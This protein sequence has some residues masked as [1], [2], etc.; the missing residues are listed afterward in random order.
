MNQDNDIFTFVTNDDAKFEIEKNIVDMSLTLM[1][2]VSDQSNN[3]NYDDIKID[4]INGKTMSQVLTYLRLSIII[5]ESEDSSEKLINNMT[6]DSF[7]DFILAGKYLQLNS[8][9][10]SAGKRI[11]KMLDVS[12]QEVANNSL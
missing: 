11:R 10:Q 4:N 12:P 1:K 6:G 2:L 7:Y 8:L 9:V 5:D 3:D